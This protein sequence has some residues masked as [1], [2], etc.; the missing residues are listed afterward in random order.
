MAI[1]TLSGFMVL[2]ALSAG[3]PEAGMSMKPTHEQYASGATC[4][5][6]NESRAGARKYCYYDCG[7]SKR[8]I[9]IPA[10]RP[11][12]FTIRR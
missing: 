4:S 6:T 11:C 5:L 8:T 12:A 1:A 2:A 7:G 10:G 3:T 9:L